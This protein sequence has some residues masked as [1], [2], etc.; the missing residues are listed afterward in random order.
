M[1]NKIRKPSSTRQQAGAQ[2]A[3]IAFATQ[4]YLAFDSSL[5]IFCVTFGALY[6]GVRCYTHF[7]RPGYVG[8]N[9]ISWYHPQIACWVLFCS[10]DLVQDKLSC[11]L[12]CYLHHNFWTKNLRQRVYVRNV[13][14]EVYG[15][16]SFYPFRK[17]NAKKDLVIQTQW[18]V[19]DFRYVAFLPQ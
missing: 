9:F 12:M 13:S 16:I 3:G 17:Q 8:C 7:A 18:A 15:D 6:C 4:Y 1:L 14:I 10:L 5:G 11:T 19:K 2:L